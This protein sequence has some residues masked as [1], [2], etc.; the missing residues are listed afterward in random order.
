MIDSLHIKNFRGFRDLSLSGLRPINIV[1]GKNASGKTALLEAVRVGLAGTPQVLYQVNQSRM[2]GIPLQLG[3]SRDNFENMWN[4][5]F[6]NL[7][8][9]Q[10]I[11]FEFRDSSK[12]TAKLKIFYDAERAVT[13]IPE[14]PSAPPS[15][16]APLIFERIDF[17]GKKSRLAAALLA[18]GNLQFEQGSESGIVSEFFTSQATINAQQNAASFSQLSV[19]NRDREIVEAMKE[20]FSPLIEDLSVLS[21]Y[22]VPSLYALVPAI[23]DKVPLSLLSSG[24]NKLFSILAS[25]IVR[26]NGAV[27]IDEIDNSFHYDRLESIWKILHRLSKKYNTQV[28][29][30]THSKEC[31]RALSKVI[32]NHEED[33]AL[34]RAEH[35]ENGSQITRIDGRFLESAIEHDFEVR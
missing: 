11:S 17:A 23:K 12:R 16:I 2:P 10:P 34:L 24:I 21:P 14:L 28:F 31:L 7:D 35:G 13:S 22:N 26:G 4:S 30:S 15:N 32:K 33:F 27:F 29:A 8:S 1:V 18:Q 25:M 9:S 19:N 6:Y 3:P 20:E 5:D